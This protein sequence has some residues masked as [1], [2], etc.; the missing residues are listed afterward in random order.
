[1][2]QRPWRHGL[3]FVLNTFRINSQKFETT[4]IMVV[5]CTADSVVETHEEATQTATSVVLP[6]DT[7]APTATPEPIE[8]SP[9]PCMIAF[10]SF[11]DGNKEIYRM[12]P[13]GEDPVNLTNNGGDDFD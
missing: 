7:P 12:G 8:I 2:G 4:C 9:I 1:M 5:S 13:E 6:S 10:D 11:R 3:C